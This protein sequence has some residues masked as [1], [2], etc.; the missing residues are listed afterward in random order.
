VPYGSRPTPPAVYDSGALAGSVLRG[1]VPNN[2]GLRLRVLKAQ[3]RGREGPIEG[4]FILLDAGDNKHADA[5][6][7]LLHRET[8]AREVL[9]VLRQ[10]RPGCVSVANTNILAAEPGEGEVR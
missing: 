8:D 6:R 4:R 10:R 7:P 3:A 1:I 2:Q 5:L 9:E